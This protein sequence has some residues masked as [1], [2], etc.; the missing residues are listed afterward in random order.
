MTLII[1]SVVM[2]L[3]CVG[4]FIFALTVSKNETLLKQ[5]LNELDKEDNDMTAYKRKGHDV[6][7]LPLGER[8][9]YPYIMRM[10]GFMKKITPKGYYEQISEKLVLAGN[11]R[12]MKAN[13]FMGIQGLTT[14]ILP[15]GVIFFALFLLKVSTLYALLFGLLAMGF[16]WIIPKMLLDSK[17]TKRQE[18]I[19]KTL[20]FTLDLLNVSVDAGL[21]FD[22]AMD[23]VSETM[24]GP[25][26]D[27]FERV[28]SEIRLGKTRK[29]ALGN[30]VERTKVEDL[31]Q[32]VVAIVQADKLGVG[33]S[34]LLRV[35][36][37]QMRQTAK[38]RAQEKAFKAPVKMLFPM[39]IFIFPSIF[40]ILLGP[41]V[42]QVLDIFK[43]L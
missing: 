12:G 26:A 6:N 37:K 41:A 5:R 13:E 7:E 22:S 16:G 36:S 19:M 27:E 11:P 29:E 34:K 23:K 35:Q 31:K 14:F 15:I 43:N 30:M 28:L 2:G 40:I 39:I 8:L 3:L 42:M 32:F 21:G 17:I 25:I 33:L 20:P 9:F 10:A 18:Q 38:Q 1:A 4:M 24:E